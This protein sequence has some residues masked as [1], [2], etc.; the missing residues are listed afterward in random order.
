PRVHVTRRPGRWVALVL[1]A[2]LVIAGLGAV[3]AGAVGTRFAG[4]AGSGRYDF[5]RVSWTQ[6]TQHP[7]QGAGADNFAHDYARDRRGREEPL[8]PHS[9]EW[10]TLGQ[11]GVVGA[12]LLATFFV[13]A[14]A[15]VRRSTADSVTIAALVSAAAW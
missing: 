9:I 8:Y 1:V 14:C 10:R 12:L 15:T 13:A 3:V 4:G 6:L 11:T 2:A 7:L 5:W